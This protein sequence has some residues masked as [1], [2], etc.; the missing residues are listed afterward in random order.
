M[1]IGA[2]AVHHCDLEPYRTTTGHVR[3]FPPTLILQ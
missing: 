2:L 1:P 3:I